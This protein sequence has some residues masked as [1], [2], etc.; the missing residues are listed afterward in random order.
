MGLLSAVKLRA[1]VGYY[2]AGFLTVLLTTAMRSEVRLVL[3]LNAI[4]TGFGQVTI[5]QSLG[6]HEAVMEA[7]SRTAVGGSDHG[8]NSGHCG[9]SFTATTAAATP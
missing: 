7:V 2:A 9:R 8:R 6:P 5:G 1:L 3:N 4:V